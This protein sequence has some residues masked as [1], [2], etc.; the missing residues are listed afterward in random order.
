MTDALFAL[1]DFVKLPKNLTFS[2]HLSK[3][4][5]KVVMGRAIGRKDGRCAFRVGRFC[6]IAEEPDF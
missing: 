1:A 4:E 5:I 6:E 3:V 2:H